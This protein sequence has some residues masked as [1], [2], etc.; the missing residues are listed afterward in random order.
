MEQRAGG[1]EEGQKVRSRRSEVRD[2]KTAAYAR[3]HGEPGR[4][5]GRG[6]LGLRCRQRR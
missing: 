2:Q 1:K 6:K 3:G 4:T 5:E